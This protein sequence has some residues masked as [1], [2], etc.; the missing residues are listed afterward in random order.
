MTDERRE[1]VRVS[2]SKQ[3]RRE[4]EGGLHGVFMAEGL[5][6]CLI[7]NMVL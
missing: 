4:F 6:R 1:G 3:R 2:K 7:F 5:C